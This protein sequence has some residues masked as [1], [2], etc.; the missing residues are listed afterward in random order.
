MFHAIEEASD[1]Q[2]DRAMHACKATKVAIKEDCRLLV[3][4]VPAIIAKRRLEDRRRDEARAGGE[5]DR[6]RAIVSDWTRTGVLTT[7][8]AIHHRSIH[9][10][11]AGH[12]SAASLF[13]GAG[14]RT[15]HWRQV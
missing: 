10:L 12:V 6:L 11:G 8:W 5:M 14:S 3:Q 1:A 7:G 13:S 15:G 9:M 4:D 2:L